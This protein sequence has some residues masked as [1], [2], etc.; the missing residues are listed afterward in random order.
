MTAFEKHWET[1][2]PGKREYLSKWTEMAPEVLLAFM[3]GV[4]WGA[5]PER[6]KQIEAIGDAEERE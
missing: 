6:R 1:I 2:D 3:E 4:A 5:N